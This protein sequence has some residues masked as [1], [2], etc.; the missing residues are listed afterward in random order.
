MKRS[1]AAVIVL[2]SFLI[3]AAA[4]AEETR[5]Y[6]VGT[7]RPFAAGTLRAVLGASAREIRAGNV[8]GL[9]SFDGFAIDLT[10]ADA[11]ALRRS[12]EIRFIEPVVER[13][14]LGRNYEGQTLPWGLTLINAP[15]AW[16]GH[17]SAEVNV[18]VADTGIDYTH[19]DLAPLYAGGMNA[20]NSVSNARDDNGHGSHVA[21]II[22]ASDNQFGVVGV[23][24]VSGIRL[25]AAKVLA[26][27]GKGTSESLIKSLDW[28]IAQKEALGGRWVMNF[29]LGA[30][31]ISVAEQQAFSR[32]LAAGIV[33]V[34]ASGNESTPDLPAA[35]VYPAAYQGVIA[36]GAIDSASGIADFSN[37][38][39]ELDL[40]APGVGVF[41]TSRVNGGALTYVKQDGTFYDA[42]PI[43]GS[44]R[45]TVIG[46]YVYC[47]LGKEGEFP[48]SVSGRIALIKRGDIRFS[49]KAKRAKEAGAIAV[50]IFNH[51]ASAMNWGLIN[52]DEPDSATYDWPLALGMTRQD[53]EALVARGSGTIMLTYTFDHYEE[54]SGTSMASP[55]VAGALALLWALAPDATAE[56]LAATLTTTAH[57]LGAAGRD[58]VYGAGI[59][60]VEAAARQLAPS[61]FT[62]NS[63][64]QRPTTGRRILRRG[65]G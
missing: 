40:V 65:R 32:A 59:I 61:A 3:A 44:R 63:E 22:A 62:T 36:V 5:R 57:D 46:E 31:T 15:A 51:D 27:N 8:E 20:L 52:D 21:G 60:D 6:L 4:Q 25:W 34:G 19:P 48:P 13:Y 23:A 35:V 64:P 55:H 39:P 29:S 14:A 41:S 7:K 43:S 17:R 47:G 49:E 58:N 24:G 28:A 18:V 2:L 11:A 38:G 30:P 45:A 33:I 53:G 1:T 9:R 42:V 12:G 26:S 16:A 50:A 54:L 10:E 56:T 37:Q